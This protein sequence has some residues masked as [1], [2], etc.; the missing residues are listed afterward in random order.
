MN[1]NL[2]TMIIGGFLLAVGGAIGYTAYF[3]AKKNEQVMEE[4]PFA[5][6]AMEESNF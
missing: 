5:D 1:S 4:I 3:T 6:E 2:R